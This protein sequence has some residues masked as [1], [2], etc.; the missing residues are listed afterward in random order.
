MALSDDVPAADVTV[1]VPTLPVLLC[2]HCNHPPVDVAIQAVSQ[3]IA[4]R[5]SLYFTE[6]TLIP[7]HL[8]PD[9]VRFECTGAQWSLFQT[10]TLQHLAYASESMCASSQYSCK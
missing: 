2:V 5:V 1:P 6:S 9:A 7:K 4:Y 8:R 3:S 10:F